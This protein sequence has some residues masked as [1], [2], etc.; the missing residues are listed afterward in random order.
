MDN[1]STTNSIKKEMTE[2]QKMVN[3]SAWMTAASMISRILGIIYIIPWMAW[4]GSQAN[5]ANALFQIGY[6]PYAFFLAL[7]T[8]GV[9][10]AISKQISHYNAIGEYE[11]SKSIYKQGLKLMAFT[12]IVSAAALYVL[13]PLLAST[14]PSENTQD[15]VIVMRALVPALLIIPSQSVTRGFLQGHN[16]MAGP[17]ISQIIE[18]FARIVFMLASAYIITQVLLGEGEGMV[19]AVSYSTFAAFIGAVFSLGYLTWKI[20]RIDTAFNH[21]AEESAGKVNVSSNALLKGIIKTSIPFIIIATGITLFQM[22]DQI[23]Y[24]P[25]M[26][27]L[28]NMDKDAIEETYGISQANAHKLKMILTSFGTALSIT[29]VPLISNL[30]AKN[31]IGEVSRQFSKGVQLLFFV[32][33]PAAV[34]MAVVAEPL[35][36]VF[37]EPSQLGTAVTQVSAYMSIFIA[38]YAVLGNMLQA[39]NQVRP[40]IRAL[41]IGFVVKL[42]TQ[43][44]F[45]GFLGFGVYGMLYST[46]AGFGVTCWLM[47]RIMHRATNY[48]ASL[49]LRRS[50]L[51]MIL[52]LIM[53]VITIFAREGLG[54]FLNY[55]SKLQAGL[56]LP[57][58][59]II[60][61]VVYGYLVLK[62]RIADRLLGG[63]AVKARNKLRM[64]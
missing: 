60:G 34:G 5:A 47:M 58:I 12:G 6:T 51:I 23:T 52:S 20:K 35:Y 41:I 13:A 50:I 10:S 63:P 18:Q 25:I 7:A 33:F 56:S 45:V 29:T 1:Q 54:L 26:E 57:I 43:P 9:P 46:I 64:K 2:D 24:A 17:A 31:N 59:G 36:N 21:S 4:M 61:I 49:L 42:V 37:Y 40:A 53:G 55:D 30:M 62:T 16:T 19:T 48:S 27:W 38:L 14:S 8:A 22:I 3:G 44:L 32:M 15:A 11:V 39:A 28:S